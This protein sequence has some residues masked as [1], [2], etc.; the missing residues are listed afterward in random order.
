MDCSKLCDNMNL[1][2]F[3]W[4]PRGWCKPSCIPITIILILIVLVVLLPL[5]EQKE[6]DCNKSSLSCPQTCRYKKDYS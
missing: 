5:M 4:G 6:A 1:T 2:C 3:R